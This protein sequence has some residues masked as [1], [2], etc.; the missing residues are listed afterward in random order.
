M[1]TL[2]S[3]VAYNDQWQWSAFHNPIHQT[4]NPIQPNQLYNKSTLIQP[5]CVY[6]D[7]HCDIKPWARAA[8]LSLLNCNA[9]DDSAFH[10]SWDG[11][12]SI[13]FIGM[14]N[15]NK[16]RLLVWMLAAYRCTH[17]P[18]RLA[19]FEGWRPSGAQSAFIKMNQ[20]NSRNG[21]AMMTAP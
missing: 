15:N 6:H 5:S 1:R 10:P 2:V 19:W 21:L 13:S 20:L 3:D 8:H 7:S 14:N 18:G 12:M 16:Q 11:K 9:Y 17:M 4:L